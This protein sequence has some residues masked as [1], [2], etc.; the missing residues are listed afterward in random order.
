M[1]IRK[2]AAFTLL[3]VLV[4]TCIFSLLILGLYFIFDKSHSIWDEANVSLE[5]YQ[6]I[7]S[8]LDML[9]EELKSAFVSPSNPSISFE[10]KEDE[11]RFTCSSNLPHESGQY[12]LKNVHYLLKRSNLIKRTTSSFDLPERAP[13]TTIL[14]SNVYG[15]K[16]SYY[17]RKK[18][19]SSCS[20]LPRAVKVKI[21]VAPQG[22]TPITFSTV[23]S[24]PLSSPQP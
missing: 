2:I 21:S 14:A 7:R 20:V 15:L 12:D 18:W 6:K 3:E 11:V 17:K 24:L 16:F 10:G 5:E 19:Q 13:S 9:T 22:Q 4:A 23:V 1:S 8:C